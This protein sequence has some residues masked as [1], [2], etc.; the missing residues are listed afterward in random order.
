MATNSSPATNCSL[1]EI[2][3]AQIQGDIILCDGLTNYHKATLL[4]LFN[5]FRIILLQ[6]LVLPVLPAHK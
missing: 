6:K 2:E 1:I 4:A 3:I 5:P